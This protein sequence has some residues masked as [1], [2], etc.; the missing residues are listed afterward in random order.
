M[1]G[2]GEQ[3]GAATD[4]P[5]RFVLF[6]AANSIC[7]Q[8]VRAVLAHHRLSYVSHTV[9]LFTGQTYFPEYVRLRMIGCASFGGSLVSRHQ[10]STSA[11]AGCDGVVVPTLVDRQADAVIV[12]SRRICLMLDQL[13]SEEQRLRT[14]DLA[15]GIDAELAIVDELPNYQLLMG[16]Q[17]GESASTPASRAAFSQR[18]VAWCDRYLAEHPNEPALVAAYSAK[19]AKELSAATDLFSDEAMAAAL[20]KM[21]SAL[22]ELERKLACRTAAWLIGARPTMADLFWGIQLVRLDD[23]GFGLA[24]D[25]ARRPHIADYAQATQSLPA[26][27]SAIIAWPGATLS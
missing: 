21:Q 19:R 17:T 11:S 6:H 5:P 22:D 12:D 25:R 4:A 24:G 18:K 9:N 10:G 2:T 23:L 15:A 14:T 16:R 1:G 3:V 8:K 27:Q 7:S 20:A 13:V 26:L